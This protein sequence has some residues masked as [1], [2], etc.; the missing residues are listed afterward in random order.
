M[1]NKKLILL[2]VTVFNFS[3]AAHAGLVEHY[4]KLQQEKNIPLS[5]EKNIHV[6]YFKQFLDH[7][8]PAKGSF[9]QRYY[10]DET[11]G[12][13]LNSPVFFYICGESSCSGRALNGAIR[14]YAQKFHAKLIALEHRYYGESQPFNTL[15][16]QNLH[17][18]ST[19]KALDDL[20]YFQ[21]SISREK[22]WYGKWI[23]FGG[24]YPGSLSAYYRLKFPY[25][26]TGALASSAPVMAK[27]DFIEYDAH[28]TQVAG[29]T[30]ANQMREV[31]SAIENS[32][33]D[34]QQ[35]AQMKALFAATA[36]EDPVDFLYLIAD[37]G[38]GAVQYGQRD[39]FCAALA[40]SNNPI[41]GYANY[42]KQM[43]KDLHI[44]AVDLTP[45]GAMSTNADLYK[46][47]VGARQWYYQSCTE[48]GYWQNAN[49]HAIYSTRS[50][51]I[52]LDYHHKVC[53]RLFG[54][55]QPAQTSN[56][57][58]TWYFPLMDILVSNIYF[59]NGENDPWSTLS[60]TKKNG[61]AI[62]P[63]LNYHL[64]TGAAHCD[65]L[66]TPLAT[67]SESL[68]QSRKIMESLLNRWLQQ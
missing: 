57:N 19:E 24:S 45:Q 32:L 15:S 12:P 65:D 35:L 54:L 56:I 20:A 22:S 13:E 52:N 39:A 26:V 11:Y 25:L 50:T 18:L 2:F 46:S 38:A 64:I 21:R 23:T 67:D 36:I 41:E 33:P 30:C 61:N 59:T 53:A 8:D 40:S 1:F 66:H 27:E 4:L 68:V 17:F 16:T 28:V 37:I 43:Y 55:S 9:L 51:L 34:A 7:N 44:S 10:I 62:N 49:P 58:N 3:S 6:G 60:L 47:G 63:K 31:V 5:A 14:N 48:Y 29:E 42:A